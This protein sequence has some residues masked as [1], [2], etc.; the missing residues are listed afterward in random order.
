M[1]PE[2]VTEFTPIGKYDEEQQAISWFRK[3]KDKVMNLEWKKVI[4]VSVIC[5]GNFIVFCSVSL[6][7]AFFPT[8]VS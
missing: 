7:G 4:L 6:I 5:A 8:K 1:E 3:A 2:E